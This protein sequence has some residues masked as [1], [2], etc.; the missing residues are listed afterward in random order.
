MLVRPRRSRKLERWRSMT[1]IRNDGMLVVAAFLV[2]WSG[3][4]L[5]HT[6]AHTHPDDQAALNA[7]S[8]AWNQVSVSSPWI[9]DDGC[10]SYVGVLCDEISGRVTQLN[11]ASQ[12]ISGVIPPEIGNFPSLE[13][14]EL[15]INPLLTGNLP[16]ELGKLLNLKSL[17]IQQCGITGPI[18]VELSNLSKLE[19]LALNS[20]KMLGALPHQ[21]G[22]LTKLYWFDISVNGFS[23][24]LPV[25]TANNDSLGLD[26]MTSI[27][28]FHFNNNSLNGNIPQEIF[29]LPN[30]IHLLLDS[31][32]LFGTIPTNV[33]IAPIQIMRLDNNKLIGPIPEEFGTIKSL[34]EIHVSN[35]ALTGIIPDL[36]ACK[37]LRLL[38]TTNNQFDPQLIPA[39]FTSGGVGMNALQTLYMR[40][41]NLVGPIPSAIFNL[42]NLEK[43]DL[44]NNG[45]NGT[46]TFGNVGPL[47][48]I[49]DLEGNEIDAIAG[50]PKRNGV[51]S[52]FDQLLLKGN[53]LCTESLVTA[54]QF[55]VADPGTSMYWP[56]SPVCDG[57]TCTTAGQ[58][59]DGS[60]CSCGN[61]LVCD[62]I[63]N[64]PPFQVLDEDHIDA[65]EADL[66]DLFSEDKRVKEKLVPTPGQTTLDPQQLYIERANITENNR[67]TFTVGI[68]PPNGRDWTAVEVQFITTF[69][70]NNSVHLPPR[71]GP[72]NMIRFQQPRMGLTSKS[73]L[74]LGALIG[75]IAGGVAVFVIVLLIGFYAFRQKRRADRAEVLTRPFA[76]WGNG[77][78]S[79]NGAAPQL[80]GARWFSVNELK[81]ATN[82]FSA[83]SQIGVGGY[84]KVYKALLASGEVVAVKRAQEGSMQGATEFKNEIELLSRVHHRN[85]VG[86]VGFCYEHGEQMLVYEFMSYG[87]LR[88]HLLGNVG[89][90][91]S[92]QA[93]LNIALGSAKG[94]SY[95]HELANPP[96][97]HRDIKSTNI[98][99]DDK[100]TA[101]V[102]DFGLSKLA[103]DD[104]AGKAHV[105]TQVKG[106]L[107]YLDPEYYMTQRLSEKSD[108]YSFGVVLLELLTARAPIE[109]GK[110]I[111]R[112]VRTALDKGGIAALRPMLDRFIN[113]APSTELE[114]FLRLALQC[115]EEAAKDRPTMNEVV[116]DLER[117]G[118]HS[119]SS[120]VMLTGPDGRPLKDPYNDE[121]FLGKETQFQYSG[122]F[123]VPTEV[124]PK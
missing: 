50:T 98:L 7:L 1:I 76:S 99:L 41:S 42:P 19:F 114:D 111:V 15:S 103:P 40:S 21:L 105:S 101:K 112:E 61:A 4:F 95:L 64:S 13:S 14:L 62:M 86:L 119:F 71:Q 77:G 58:Y 63:L 94:L 121:V 110:Y 73:S 81:K 27:K 70:F 43:I 90:H 12:N 108:V 56:Q 51:N 89:D 80:K 106:T 31:N 72:Y 45:L 88:D 91:L 36:S 18:P 83:S 59:L 115:V 17:S 87:T 55:C 47:L 75:I 113:E 117:I 97:I 116:K 32:Q 74:G 123:T 93:R 24:A 124:I 44:G 35:N 60:T 49:V 48:Q 26:T 37:D 9:G 29:N 82:N 107:G 10:D 3:C 78:G 85:L 20:N 5:Q 34:T 84:G 25:S 96:I 79:D 66:A 38:D 52:N 8:D 6:A 54:E 122:G 23:Q 65:L 68:F 118:G 102:A 53:P 22:K 16:K 69:L 30:L 57:K 39:F 104:G 92:W 11:L 33:S 2:F 109:K 46:L 100:M 67:I 120:S 28:H